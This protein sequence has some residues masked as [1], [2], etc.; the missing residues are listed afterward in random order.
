[1]S[2]LAPRMKA[3]GREAGHLQAQAP[4]VFCRMELS[5]VGFFPKFPRRAD[6]L[7][8]LGPEA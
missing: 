6:L 1:M 8:Q 4:H 7:H 3:R 5:F 2:A